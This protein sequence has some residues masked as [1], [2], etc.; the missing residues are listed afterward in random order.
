VGISEYPRIFKKDY[1]IEILSLSMVLLG[2]G[3]AGMRD[4]MYTGDDDQIQTTAPTLDIVEKKDK[5][6]SV[7]TDLRCSW[8]V[9]RY[10][11]PPVSGNRPEVAIPNVT[12]QY[13]TI[14]VI[15]CQW[16]KP[17]FLLHCCK[18]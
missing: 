13:Y 16:S 7:H 1:T 15:G 11:P 18:V 6:R 4:W 5:K 8:G 10:H 17:I 2:V 14:R 3:R 9:V 12:L